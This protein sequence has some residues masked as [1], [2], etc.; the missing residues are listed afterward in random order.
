MAAPLLL[1]GGQT[2]S[3]FVDIH[4]NG[5]RELG[6]ARYGILPRLNFTCD[7]RI[8]R[9]MARIRNRTSGDRND[10]PYFQVWRPLSTNSMVLLVLVKFSYKR[11]K[12]LSVTV[13]IT[14]LLTLL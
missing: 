7:G 5:W 13:I 3:D 11:V 6:G 8:T 12:C 14:A 10:Y 1:L 4:Q 9:I 2:C